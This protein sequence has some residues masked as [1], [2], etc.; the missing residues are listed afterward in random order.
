MEKT[1]QPFIIKLCN[2]MFEDLDG[3]IKPIEKNKTLLCDLLTEKFVE[4]KLSEGDEQVFD[5]E[6]EIDQFLSLCL[7]NESLER[8][9]EQR[10]IGTFDDGES[11]FLTEEGKKY[12][13]DQLIP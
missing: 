7:T 12:V 10:L 9:H 13:E 8:L 1:Y 11:Y 4:G 3:D 5:S 2:Q 6:E